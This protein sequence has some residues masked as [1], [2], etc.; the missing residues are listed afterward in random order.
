MHQECFSLLSSCDA[1]S[2]ILRTANLEIEAGKALIGRGD[3]F[4]DIQQL[5][6]IMTSD[7]YSKE[8]RAVIAEMLAQI[9]AKSTADQDWINHLSSVAN[10]LSTVR[11]RMYKFSTEYIYCTI[12]IRRYYYIYTQ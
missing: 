4:P 3:E 11:I 8:Y 9:C 6:T 2:L 5:V 10:A 12:H 1:Y 7:A